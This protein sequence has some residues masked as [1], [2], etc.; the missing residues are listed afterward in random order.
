MTWREGGS[1]EHLLYV[2]FQ[3][4]SHVAVKGHTLPSKHSWVC[5]ARVFL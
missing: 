1:A 2:S 3:Y 5:E 4:E